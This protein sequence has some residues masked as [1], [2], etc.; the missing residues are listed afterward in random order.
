[1]GNC[2]DED[3]INCIDLYFDIYNVEDNEFFY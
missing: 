2:E 3:G 1:M